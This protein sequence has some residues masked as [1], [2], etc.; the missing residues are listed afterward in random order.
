LNRAEY[1]RTGIAVTTK[2]GGTCDYCGTYIVNMFQ[3]ESADG[4]RFKVG[5]DCIAKT[6]DEGLR[7]VV[8][9]EVARRR[10]EAAAQRALAK[11]GEV[12]AALAD[13]ATRAKL[14]AL[15]H[16][17]NFSGLSLLDY[18]E[19]MLAHAGRKGKC[20]VAKIVAEAI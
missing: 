14:A 5:S 19:W 11:I 2:P 12:E 9:R 20:T 7:K 8:D 3:V 17:R 10:K 18:C 15:P 4:R 6:G 1:E 16:P 13:D